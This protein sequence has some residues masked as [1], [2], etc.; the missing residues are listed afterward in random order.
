MHDF[1]DTLRQARETRGV[2]LRQISA[3]TKIPLAALEALERNDVSKLPGG[4]FS[5]SFVRSYA[6]EIG[7]DPDRTV[8]EFLERFHVEPPPDAEVHVVSEAEAARETERHAAGL[9]LRAILAVL[10]VGGVV[11][12]FVFRGGRDAPSQA[13]APTPAPRAEVATTPPST[14][15]PAV[16]AVDD[17]LRAT[18]PMRLDIH[19]TGPCWIKLTADGENVFAKIMQAGQKE[20]ITVRKSAV[21]TI[22]DAGAFAYSIDGRPGKSLGSSGEVTTARISRETLAEY[23]R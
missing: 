2:S 22:G 10:V 11:G 23:L 20:S 21:I 19:P 15:A 14:A 8:S 3:K 9:A 17:V 16:P 13:A 6:G 7:L 1:G 5:R 12:F 18:G 4:I